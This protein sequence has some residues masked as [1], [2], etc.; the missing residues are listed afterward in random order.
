[1]LTKQERTVLPDRQELRALFDQEA[2][3]VS[4]RNNLNTPW[5]R[6]LRDAVFDA[7][8]TALS[9]FRSR[10][11]RLLTAS[12]PCGAGKT[13]FAWAFIVA[14]THH[15]DKHPDAPQGCVFVTD[16]I[17]R[18][19]E[20]YRD[21]EA[22]LPGKVAIWTS[23]HRDLFS[24]EK[25]RQYP[26]IVVTGRFYLGPNGHLAHSVNSRND[27]QKRALTI[28]DERPEEVTTYEILLSE[29]QKVREALIEKRPDVKEPI[30]N[31]LL[32]MEPYSYKPT[33][34]IYLPE[35]TSNALAWF[36]SGDAERLW[37]P[38]KP[39]RESAF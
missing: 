9:D 37:L 12:A 17:Q 16:R 15:A 21:L 24:R 29:A 34:K 23:E 36:L 28:V 25:L 8:Y 7:C 38:W 6:K 14:I 32:F 27:F 35:E 33:N 30:D 39:R 18:A 22:A 4:A 26:V 19:D 1:L 13:S 11:R 20:V 5:H 2:D 31:L 10:R 3:V